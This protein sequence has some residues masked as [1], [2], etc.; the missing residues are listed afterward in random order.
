M[1]RYFPGPVAALFVT[2]A[3]LL[4]SPAFAASQASRGMGEG[5]GPCM[6]I[7]TP[8]E[9]RLIRRESRGWP[10]ARNPSSSAFGCGQLLRANRIRFAKA[11]GVHP[12]TL[13]VHGQMCLFR[14]YYMGR[15]GSAERALAHSRRY[16]WF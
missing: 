5:D 3:A 2:V 7:A 12:D 15:F 10:T 14:K 4:P 6:A 1:K 8:V 13:N 11:C 9:R 16:G